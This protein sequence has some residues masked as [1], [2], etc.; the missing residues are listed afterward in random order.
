[1]S[2][3]D[4][5]LVAI[6]GG[7][8]NPDIVD[9][10]F[11]AFAE[12]RIARVAVLTVAAKKVN[13]MSTAYNSMFRKRNV[14]HV[15]MINISSRK[16]AYSGASLK[17]IEQADAIYF[18]GGDQLNITS[19]FGGSPLD[20]LLHDKVKDG[21]V[22]GGTSAGA[23]MMGT[24]MILDGT[25]DNSPESGGVEISSGLD[26]IKNS[27]IDTHFAQRGRHGRLLAALAHH[28]HLLYIGIDE[29]TAAMVRGSQLRVVG[30]ASVTIISGSDVS[31]VDLVYRKEG[32][33]ISIFDVRLHVLAE[34]DSFDLKTRLP[35]ARRAAFK[36]AGK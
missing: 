20:N 33:P 34:G 18:T 13:G 30:D 12:K 24:S 31:H 21:V 5:T 25:G 36:T 3:S 15:S 27:L 35:K 1:M 10:F 7:S 6:G 22:V 14:N 11:D 19:L 32:D 17:K 28:P 29:S 2:R 26:L 23:S 4:S 8:S 9:A 16:D